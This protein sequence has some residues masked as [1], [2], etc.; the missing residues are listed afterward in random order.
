MNFNRNLMPPRNFDR[1]IDINYMMDRAL[2]YR[3][4]SLESIR[5]NFNFIRSQYLFC[6]IA[7]A[8][9]KLAPDSKTSSAKRFT[10][11]LIAE[12]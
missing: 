8:L 5:I 7:I 9:I 10:I 11:N 3:T 1:L 12:D 2:R 4:I 6:L